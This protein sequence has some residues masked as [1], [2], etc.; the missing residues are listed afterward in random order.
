MPD[1]YFEESIY[2]QEKRLKLRV[3]M[4]AQLFAQP[5]TSLVHVRVNRCF[6]MYRRLGT[7]DEDPE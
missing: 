5:S 4:K 3:G 7:A 1:K 6:E 2:P